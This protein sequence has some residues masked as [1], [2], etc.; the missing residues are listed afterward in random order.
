MT[1]FGLALPVDAFITWPTRKPKAL[2]R[3]LRDLRHGVGIGG[4][5]VADDAD[6][7]VGVADLREALRRDDLVRGA[8]AVEHL[9]EDVLGDRVADGA[10]IDAPHQPGQ[11]VRRQRHLLDGDRRAPSSSAAA[12]P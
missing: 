10:A 7:R 9:R 1:T 5:R 6:E 3:P 2:L 8:A 12:R 4:D 11:R